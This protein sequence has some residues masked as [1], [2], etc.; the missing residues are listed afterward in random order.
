MSYIFVILEVAFLAVIAV[1]LIVRIIVG[2]LKNG[3][4]GVG[5]AFRPF[6]GAGAAQSTFYGFTPQETL[7]PHAEDEAEESVRSSQE[8]RPERHDNRD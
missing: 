5:N 7:N 3:W 4:R 1:G 6:T 2:A 8:K